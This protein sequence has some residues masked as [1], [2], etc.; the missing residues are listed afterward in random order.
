MK[1]KLKDFFLVKKILEYKRKIVIRNE[2]KNDYRFFLSNYM[3]SK[4][5][6]INK[7]E[8]DIMLSIHQLEKGMSCR[9]IRPFGKDKIKKII[10]LLPK[11]EKSKGYVYNYSLSILSKYVT[12]YKDN[13]WTDKIE[14]QIVSDFIKN[15]EFHVIK[16]GSIKIN[17][18]DFAIP[19][20]IDFKSFLQSRH[21][22]RNYSSKRLLDEDIIKAVEMSLL[23]P[24]ACN[25]QMCK[26]YFISEKNKNVIKE[27][28]QGLGLFEL[29]N[30]NYFLIT[31]D[32][33]SNYFVG[34]RNQGWF[35]AGLLSM[36]FINALHSL[37]I[38]SCPIQFGNSYKEEKLIKKI[39]NIP[40]NERIAVIITA[41]YYANESI[42]PCSTRKKIDQIYKK[43]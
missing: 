40:E 27:Y 23:T 43:L 39:L 9:K 38:G 15:K 18:D 36:N 2:F 22:V 13:N 33:N 24:S 25:R 26:I 29:E 21:S 16:C 1:E 5:Q 20:Q 42:V 11:L 28:A 37:G 35:N 6:T 34:E 41:G 10:T 19:S 14:Y 32:V 12:I 3:Y 31:F 4:T 30:I 8:Y 17:K 7:I